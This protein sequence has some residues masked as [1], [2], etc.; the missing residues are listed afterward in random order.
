MTLMSIICF[1]TSLSIVAY[2]IMIII[3]PFSL[4]L[5]TVIVNKFMVKT[6]SLF[7]PL[8]LTGAWI[9]MEFLLACIGMPIYVGILSVPLLQYM[10]IASVFG[11]LGVSFFIVLPQA[12]IGYALKLIIIDK[13]LMI[14]IGAVLISILIIISNTIW[15]KYQVGQINVRLTKEILPEI[16]VCTLQ[17]AFSTKD[18]DLSNLSYFYSKAVCD[19]CFNKFFTCKNKQHYLII[20]PEEPDAFYNVDVKP[21]YENIVN[22][23]NK[24]D[25]YC[26]LGSHKL[27]TIGNIYNSMFLFSPNRKNYQTYHKKQP[28]PFYEDYICAGNNETLIEVDSFLIGTLLC[29][30]SIFAGPSR[31][32]VKKDANML[33]YSTNEHYLNGSVLSLLF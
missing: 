32:L 21:L 10:Q 19:I 3:W 33:V 4:V 22:I 12:Y 9:L 18:Y 23:S 27:D 26:L 5:Y 31:E 6:G 28:L 17:T 11:I 2:C 30:E 15:G 24:L 29:N 13:K 1:G 14:S 20:W 25:A 7:T 16:N 8:F